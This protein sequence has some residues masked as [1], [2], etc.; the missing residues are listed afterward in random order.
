MTDN[1]TPSGTVTPGSLA[2]TETAFAALL[3]GEEP[4]NQEESEALAEPETEEVEVEAPDEPEAEQADDEAEPEDDDESDEQE[5]AAPTYTIKVDGEEVEVT[6]DEL[7]NGY[8][9]TQDYTRKTQKL[10]EDRKVAQAEFEA[11]RAERAQYSTLLEALRQQ[12]DAT[13]PAEPDWDRLRAEDPIEFGVQWA[14]HQRRQQQ[15]AAIQAEQA[16]V[17]QIQQYEQVEYL[18]GALE[19]EKQAL[20]QVVP[21]WK[22]PAKAKA[23]KAELIEFGKKVG[24][25]EA[26]LN[27]VTDHRAVV[28]LRNA[29]LYDKLMSRKTQ[30]KPVQK[31]SAPVLKP[32]AATMVPKKSSELTRAKQRL[33]K[34]GSVRDA[35]AAFEQILLGK[36]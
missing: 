31:P 28:A 25:T 29:M 24:F 8:S 27:A 14:E 35:A 12:V 36:G 9:R 32:G 10:A 11:V 7:L 3:S 18:K 34:T 13:A 21:E 33:A 5:E 15:R 30:V 6:L 23:E 19:Q 26:E 1:S 17:A 20:L 2:A 4:G 22:D 16:R